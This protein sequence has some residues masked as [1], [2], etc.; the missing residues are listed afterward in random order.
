MVWSGPGFSIPFGW[1]AW[2]IFGD[3]SPLEVTWLTSPL[4]EHGRV[5]YLQ[6]VKDR[7]RQ[8]GGKPQSEDRWVA[9]L[10]EE[11]NRRRHRRHLGTQVY[12]CVSFRNR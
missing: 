5:D 12:G 9:M 8:S 11:R 3:L 1:I 10:E 4:T 6:Y 2:T 7:H